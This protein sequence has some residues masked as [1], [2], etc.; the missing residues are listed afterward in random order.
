MSP[1]PI[2]G[3][4]QPHIFTVVAIVSSR[5]EHT[6]SKCERLDSREINAIQKLFNLAGLN[7]NIGLDYFGPIFVRAQDVKKKF[8]TCPFTCVSTRAL[9]LEVVA[10]N[11]TIQF[12][13]AFRRFIARRET[14]DQIISDNAPAFK[15]G[16]EVVSNDLTEIVQSQ[17]IT[18]FTTE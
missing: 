6:D 1:Q 17:E 18:D 13:L 14:P 7:W 2:T 8:W 4:G 3:D 5:V 9:H 12:I 16:M 10:D 11:T 15:L